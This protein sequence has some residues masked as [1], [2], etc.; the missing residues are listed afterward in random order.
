MVGQGESSNVS[1]SATHTQLVGGAT[2][3][4]PALAR[5]GPSTP[6]LPVAAATKVVPIEINPEIVV[7]V[8]LLV[9]CFARFWPDSIDWYIAV[10]DTRNFAVASM[11]PLAS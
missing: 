4:V 7:K 1:G 6:Q 9:V 2:Q 10:Y 5:I 8:H 3:L 11:V